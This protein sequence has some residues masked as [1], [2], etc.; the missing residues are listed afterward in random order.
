MGKGAKKMI[1][2]KKKDPNA[3]VEE[4]WK[5]DRTITGDE[6]EKGIASGARLYV[7]QS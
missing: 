6:E 1:V 5:G 7:S 2:K 3:R 4:D